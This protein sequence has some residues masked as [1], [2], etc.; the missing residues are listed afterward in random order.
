LLSPAEEGPAFGEAKLVFIN[1]TDFHLCFGSPSVVEE[2]LCAKIKPNG[3]TVWR[4]ECDGALIHPD[5]YVKGSGSVLVPIVVEGEPQLLH[6]GAARCDEETT[7]VIEHDG[8]DYV[9]T[10]TVTD[11]LAE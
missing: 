8:G 4:P 2:E 5:D 11:P 10:Q 9:V 3:R 6:S 7:F 1:R